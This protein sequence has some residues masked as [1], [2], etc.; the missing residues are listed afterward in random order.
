MPSASAIRNSTRR[1]FAELLCNLNRPSSHMRKFSAGFTT[2]GGAGAG[3][4]AGARAGAGVGAGVDAGAVA[5]P[6]AASVMVTLLLLLRP[7]CCWSTTTTTTAP[8]AVVSECGRTRS[9]LDSLRK[10]VRGVETLHRTGVYKGVI[11]RNSER[12]GVALAK[13]DD[14]AEHGHGRTIVDSGTFLTGGD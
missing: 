5:P 4:G 3:A 11:W 8:N 9:T 2:A 1:S 6:W 14:G 13:G 12:W 7:C 10:S